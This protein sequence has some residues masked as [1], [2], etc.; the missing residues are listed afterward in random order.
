MVDLLPSAIT[1][2]AGEDIYLC[3]PPSPTQL[4]GSIFGDYLI[5]GFGLG[6]TLNP[7]VTVSQSTFFVLTATAPDFS[8]NVVMN[9]DFESG[10]T[11]YFSSDYGYSP[12][13]TSSLEYDVLDNPMNDHPGF[14]D[15]DDHTS[16]AGQ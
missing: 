10:N 6:P 1:V 7:T 16:G 3:A 11:G 12:G 15:C 5:S 8:N 9:G 4:N 13:A 2:D 14:A